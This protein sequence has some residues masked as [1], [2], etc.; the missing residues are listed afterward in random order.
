MHAAVVRCGIQQTFDPL[1]QQLLNGSILH[2]LGGAGRNT[3]V[4]GGDKE[5]SAVNPS[6]VLSAFDDVHSE[7][8]GYDLGDNSVPVAALGCQRPRPGV[9]TVA[10]RLNRVGD[11]GPR[12]FRNARVFAVA[13]HE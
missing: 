3:L 4:R 1:F 7:G 13:Q 8:C 12:L 10:Q 11:A 9:R 2:A 5:E 6:L